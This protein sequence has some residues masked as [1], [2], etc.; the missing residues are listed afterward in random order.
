MTEEITAQ[1]TLDVGAMLPAY[2]WHERRSPWPKCARIFFL[3]L[4]TFGIISY[5][6]LTSISTD[7]SG[8]VTTAFLIMMCAIAYLWWSWTF[9]RTMRI[10][11]YL[12][13]IPGRDQPV[14]WT[15][16]NQ[17]ISQQIGG[18]HA[19]TDWTHVFESSAAADGALVYSQ[20]SLF[21]WLPKTAFTSEAEYQRFIELL[22]AKT[23]HSTVG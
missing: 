13:Q 1:S 11:R 10:R 8:N 7:R 23:K 17:G 18:S 19:F 14:Y 6:V 3:L 2:R 22:K 5:G 20:K 4:G 21:Y 9:G 15:I 12:R 16:N